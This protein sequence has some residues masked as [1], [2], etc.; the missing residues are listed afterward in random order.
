MSVESIR[1]VN[2]SNDNNRSFCSYSKSYLYAE[3]NLGY[4]PGV[5]NHLVAIE[6]VF[7][8]GEE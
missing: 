5:R 3:Y 2:S 8:Q 7:L 4:L 6:P 1:I